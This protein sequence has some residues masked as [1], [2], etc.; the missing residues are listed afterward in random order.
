MNY[1]QYDINK[2]KFYLP[3]CKIKA[4]PLDIY[5]NYKDK[6]PVKTCISLDMLIY[7]NAK[8]EETNLP[9]LNFDKTA[10]NNFYTMF[11][12]FFDSSIDR[13]LIEN[14]HILYKDQLQILEQ[15]EN[16][17]DLPIIQ[18]KHALSGFLRDG[19]FYCDRDHIDGIPIVKNIKIIF[20]NQWN[21]EE[22]GIYVADTP[23][24]LSKSKDT[25]YHTNRNSECID[26]LDIKDEDACVSQKHT[27]DARCVVNSDC[28]FYQ[29]NKTYKN[30]FG[31]CDNGYCEM[32]IGIIR[33]GYTKY[34]PDS[35]AYCYNGHC[36]IL[37]PDYAFPLDI[38]ERRNK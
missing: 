20:E 16:K 18:P 30:N 7:A 11:F 2:L 12:E 37:D 29:K 1:D 28:P 27:W 32:P 22:N 34:D 26:N 14:T 13:L 35:K 31:G 21:D 36:D 23:L 19:K 15:F 25:S 8:L 10:E 3:Y 33:N 5:F 38:F 24:I 4:L 6:F 17:D 9:V